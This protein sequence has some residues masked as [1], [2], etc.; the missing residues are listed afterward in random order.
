[1]TEYSFQLPD[2]LAQQLETHARSLGVKGIDL[3][4]ESILKQY[5]GSLTEGHTP[6]KGLDESGKVT[7]SEWRMRHP[8]PAAS[9][10]PSPTLQP[11]RV[12]GGWHIF[13][14]LFEAID[15]PEFL[16][17]DNRWAFYE[18]LLYLVNEDRD[19]LIDLC[20]HGDVAPN[21]LFRL[22]LV[23][24]ENGTGNWDQPLRCFESRSR[25]DIVRE[26]EAW[27]GTGT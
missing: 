13:W 18:S 1:M 24:I 4:I 20:W 8:R 2:D 17:D 15:P 6:L 22:V 19:T 14:N 26:L 21:G 7:S 5:L 9:K 16:A 25:T 12:D 10:R 3:W 23:R 11:L 27:L